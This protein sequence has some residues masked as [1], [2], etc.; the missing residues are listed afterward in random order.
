MD[1]REEGFIKDSGRGMDLRDNTA[2]V[3][4]RGGVI[5]EPTVAG[6]CPR[7]E[8]DMKNGDDHEESTTVNRARS[9]AWEEMRIATA[10][11]KATAITSR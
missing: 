3:G 2:P 11:T 9:T 1:N 5:R 7:L 6:G 8:G 10:I 4:I